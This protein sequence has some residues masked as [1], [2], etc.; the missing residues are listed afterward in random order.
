[1]F[2]RLKSWLAG[3]AGAAGGNFDAL[4]Q[5]GDRCLG[6]GR[7]A[8]AEQCY[9]QALA[10]GAPD[11]AELCVALGFAL[12]EQGRGDA[13]EA[14]LRRAVELDAGNVD[15]HYLSGR[16]YR[17]RGQPALAVESFS[18]ALDCNPAF[19]F[20][21][22]ELFETLREQGQTA[23]AKEAVQRTLGILPDAA[24]FHFHLADLLV[25]EGELEQAVAAYQR[26]EAL[27]P[28][29]LAPCINKANAL[30]KL[31]RD[32]EAAAA[33]RHALRLDGEAFD[34][35]MGLGSIGQ[36]NGD[37]ALALASYEHAQRIR[38]QSA[39][40]QV[41]LGWALEKAK[42]SEQAISC[43]RQAVALDAAYAP[44][45]QCLGNA[46][47]SQGRSPE[48]L[49]CFRE[50]L[51][52]Q[53]ENPVK[54][55]V[56][57]L[58]GESADCAPAG[59]VEQLFDEYADNF[60]EHLVKGLAYNVPENLVHL[61]AS[62]LGPERRE[63][64]VLDLGCGTG[65]FAVALAQLAEAI[66]VR[67]LVGVDISAR[68]LEKAGARKVYSRLEQSD[69]LAMMGEEPADS[70][71]LVAATDVF[72]YIGELDRLV[73]ETRRLLRPGGLF[74][75]SVESLEALAETADD[76]AG[77]DFRLN[78][79]GRYAHSRGYLE[80]L[81]ASS[82]MRVLTWREATSRLDNGRPIGGYLTVWAR[83][84]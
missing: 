83:P 36:R 1:M 57:A 60:D 30:L 46:Y 34:A 39:V 33:Y 70:Y 67:R 78:A 75:F 79:T 6:Q 15:A 61:L 42:R 27:S 32:D 72:V 37:I 17:Q 31:G 16:L 21:H 18:Q 40:V 35:H 82:D 64:D 77:R 4:R 26:A 22:R 43:F 65:L 58:S 12:L 10:E 41:N 69:L 24:E 84:A 68:M 23:A 50:V 54:H 45:H 56:A 52:L 5:E 3:S 49:A 28:E 48:A 25:D 8:D 2:A 76:P 29:S 71:D 62:C 53:P 13:A 19:E 59:Y 47:L 66:A 7:F 14:Q 44:G 9:R 63:V 20:A 38:P 73:A 55:L 80:R 11:S 51:R 74:A 81:A